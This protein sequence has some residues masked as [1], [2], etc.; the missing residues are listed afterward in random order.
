MVVKLNSSCSVVISVIESVF[1]LCKCLLPWPTCEEKS[2]L[3]K[4]TCGEKSVGKAN[5]GE[6]HPRS[7]FFPE[8]NFVYSKKDIIPGVLYL[9]PVQFLPETSVY[10]HGLNKQI[11]LRRHSSASECSSENTK[12]PST[13]PNSSK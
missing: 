10:K 5:C 6:T 2:M 12:F 3:E 1:P 8:M 13:S 7:I 11:Q 9:S 4:E